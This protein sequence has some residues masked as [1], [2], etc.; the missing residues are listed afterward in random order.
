MK[1]GKA[2]H[3]AFI[4]ADGEDPDWAIWYG[5]HLEDPLGDA[6]ETKLSASEISERLISLD[7]KFS[8]LSPAEHWT[9]FYANELLESKG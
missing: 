5:K 9:K 3:Q 1:T 6:L 8:S 2:H 7:K 4:E